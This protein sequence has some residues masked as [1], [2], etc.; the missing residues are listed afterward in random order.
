LLGE[1]GEE[2][3]VDENGMPIED[4]VPGDAGGIPQE[5]TE[6]EPLD[7]AWIDKAMGRSGDQGGQ[8][9]EDA[10]PPR[11]SGPKTVT[12]PPPRP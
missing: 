4:E 5:M 10:P 6:P 1:D 9:G 8:P 12:A 2:I 7:E 3:L 11:A